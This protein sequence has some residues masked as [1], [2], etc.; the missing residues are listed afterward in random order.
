MNILKNNTVQPLKTNFHLLPGRLRIGIPGLLNNQDLALQTAHRLAKFPGVRVSHANPFSGQVLIIFD[1]YKTDLELLLAWISYISGQSPAVKDPSQQGF[2]VQTLPPDS[3][4]PWHTLAG[5]EALAILD[6]SVETGLSHDTAQNRLEEYGLNELKD[7][8]K[9]SFWQIALASLNG[10][11]TKLL[12]AAGGV[13]LLVGEKTDAAVIGAIVA[14]QAVV[15]TAQSCR[16][17]KSLEDLKEFSI[18]LA[19][20][21]R[22]GRVQKI[23]GKELVPGDILHFN[24]GDVVPADALIIEAVNLTTNEACLTGESI[25][26]VKDNQEK[27]DPGVPVADRANILFSGT[28]IIGGRATAAVITTGIHTELGR[29]AGLLREVQSEGT[30]LQKQLDYLGKKITQLVAVSVGII[31]VINLWRGRPLWEVLRSGI[32]L[33]VGAVPEGLPAVLTVALTTGVQRMVK[34]NALVR[35]MSAVESL[36]SATVICTDKT[37]TLTKNEMTVKE[38]YVDQ[39]FYQITGD[40]YQPHGKIMHRDSAYVENSSF[41]LVRKTLKVAALCNNAE[42]RLNPN[43][44]W[45]V[46]GDPTEGALLTAAA[47]AGLYQQ[48]LQ[49]KYCRHK[50]I[51]FDAVRRLMTAVCL[52]PGG[53]YGV[54]VKGAPDAV[55]NQCS[56]AIG[57][58]GTEPLNLKTRRKILAT[59][60]TLAR[61]ALR[62]LAVAYKKLPPETDL[63]KE[64]LEEDLESE[65][66]F[67]GLIGMA[68]APREGVQEAVQKCHAAGIKV[69]MITGDHQK[70][71]EAIA[72]KLGIL[73]QGKSIT[74]RELEQISDAEFTE[75]V[76]DVAVFSRTTPDQK[77]KIVHALKSRGHIVAMTGDGV[78]DAP[79]IKKADI[80]IAMGATG[81]DV[82]REAADIT[83]SDDNFVTIVDGVEEGRTVSMNLSSSIRYILSGSLSQLLTVFAAAIW[84]L[85]TPMLPAQIL[86]VNLVTESIPAISLTADPPEEDYMNQPPFNPEGRFLPDQG[87]TIFRKGILFGLITF[88]LYVG[89][90]TWGGWSLDKA[91]TMAFSQ[92][93]VNRTFNLLNER[94]KKQKNPAAKK[95]PLVLPAAAL[96]VSMLAAT[97]YLPFMRPLFST[98]PL[99][100]EDWFL[101]IVNAMAASKIDSFLEAGAAKHVQGLQAAPAPA[102]NPL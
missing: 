7:G 96:S 99:N 94:K 62:V 84:G 8:Q 95:N 77:L 11:M 70:T 100:L 5:P 82:A 17:E 60:E 87:K 44:R 73:E 61:E 79:A 31:A 75:Q 12:L 38:L 34:R 1:P 56:F 18:P 64:D 27:N 40:G 66:I 91:R 71:A 55:L 45:T 2:N 6:S 13:S 36:G 58:A 21:L 43:G 50:E 35:N 52:E 88:G 51:A 4:L 65:L 9:L 49:E 46:M 20:V 42:L 16:A 68:D 30:N 80:G 24:A 19:T 25:P 86:W 85:P 53:E 97:L 63:E 48:N 23:P 69:V 102:P 29:I 67:C 78:N 3:S 10:F 59:N 92:L 41:P 57:K 54:Y 22:E 74:G 32:S 93:V 47:K 90:L 72:A 81:T 26:V 98:L 39:V 83:L 28:S 33:A 15:E 14:I 89:G 37:G 76:A 101:L